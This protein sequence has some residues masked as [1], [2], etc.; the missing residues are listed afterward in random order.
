MTKRRAAAAGAWICTG[1]LAAA[2]GSWLPAGKTVV[3]AKAFGAD[4]TVRL[5]VGAPP[6]S[7][8]GWR[9]GAEGECPRAAVTG[10]E[11]AVGAEPL[12]VPRSAYADLGAPSNLEVRPGPASFDVVVH[13]GD[14]ATAYAATLTFS[15]ST[16]QS[17]R[18]YNKSFRDSAWEETRYSFP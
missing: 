18:V 3:Q 12:F 14:A 2:T 1:A 5:E 6:A 17:R 9:W 4:I 13:G 7:C 11:V 10:I 16:L 15:R 8:A